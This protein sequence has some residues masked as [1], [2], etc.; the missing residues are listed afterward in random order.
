MTKLIHV[1]R[2]D[3]FLGPAKQIR[4]GGIDAQEIAVEVRDPEQIL[5]Q[6]PYAI[7]LARALLYF[8]FQSFREDTQRLFVPHALSGFKGRGKDTADAVWRRAIEN[9]AV[10][11]RKASFF[12]NAVTVDW[13]EVIFGEE[14]VELTA[15]NGFVQRSE[16]A[17][18]FRPDLPQRLSKRGRVAI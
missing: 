7:A 4:P 18:D 3:L 16:L 8:A 2:F 12:G 10:A 6:L 14:A 13:P 15:Q 9:W 5:R 1:Q 11:D 17:V